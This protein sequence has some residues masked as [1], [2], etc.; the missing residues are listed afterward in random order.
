[1]LVARSLRDVESVGVHMSP[2]RTIDAWGWWRF[3]YEARCVMLRGPLPRMQTAC[4]DGGHGPAG[5]S[6][7]STIYMPRMSVIGQTH[8]WGD[9]EVLRVTVVSGVHEAQSSLFKVPRKVEV[10]WSG[11]L[12]YRF[13]AL[14][15][16]CLLWRRTPW[17]GR[18]W[19][20]GVAV[21]AWRLWAVTR[22]KSVRRS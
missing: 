20:H 1:M 7:L 22:W 21:V 15:M 3:R 12:A 9:D 13:M 14:A 11:E 16:F 8:G 4:S 5:T 17:M 2:S 18:Q 19:G 10:V 6:L